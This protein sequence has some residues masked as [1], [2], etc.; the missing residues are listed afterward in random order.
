MAKV[1][2]CLFCSSEFY[3]ENK[4][5]HES[6][7]WYAIYDGFPVVKGHTLIIPKKHIQSIFELSE[8]STLFSFIKEVKHI[9]DEKYSPSGYNLG[10]NDGEHA[11]QTIHHLHIHMIPRYIGDC[12][13][14][15]GVRNVFPPNLAN[16]RK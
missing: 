2:D 11:G 3:S 9:L 14:P 10:I 5:I 16:Y 12:G 13:L 6:D 15:C 8:I 7:D 4:I 1:D